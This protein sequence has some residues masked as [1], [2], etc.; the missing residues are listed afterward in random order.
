MKK[1]KSSISKARSYK[2]ISAFWGTHALGDYWE[3][4]E[5]AEFGVEIQ[6]EATYFPVETA[7]SV[8]VRKIAQQKGVSP[9]TLLNLWVQEKVG[10]AHTP[11]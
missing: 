2:Q 4:T 8:K 6:T 3:R 10:K 7:L 11:K 5:P 9:E 1:N